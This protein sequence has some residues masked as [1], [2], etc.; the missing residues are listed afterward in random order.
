MNEYETGEPLRPEEDII[1]ANEALAAVAEEFRRRGLAV[2]FDGATVVAGDAI[3][4]A[5]TKRQRYEVEFDLAPVSYVPR[6]V[7]GLDTA[8]AAFECIVKRARG[9]LADIL[10]GVGFDE[11]TVEAF[12]AEFDARINPDESPVLV[13]IDGE[14]ITEA[15]LDAI[16]ADLKKPE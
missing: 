11:G 12:L 13:C 15:E 3:V 6:T 8:E 1:A 5:D 2:E 16:I 4:H 10:E 7:H 9:A 14:G